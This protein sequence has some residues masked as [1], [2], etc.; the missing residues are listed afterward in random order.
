MREHPDMWWANRSLSVSYVRLGDRQLALRS[1][2]TL[3]RRSPDLT[4]GQVRERGSVSARL[5]GPA[6]RGAEGPRPAGFETPMEAAMAR[7]VKWAF[8]GG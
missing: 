6:R 1:L 3:R 7:A 5:P 4:V 8:N 2:D